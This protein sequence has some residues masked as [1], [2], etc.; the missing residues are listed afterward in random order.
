M[1]L[2]EALDAMA[3]RPALWIG[4]PP[5]S[6]KTTLARTWL[7]ARG[8]TYRWLQLDAAD[9]DP[10]TF[11]QL[12]DDA[13]A[14]SDPGLAGTVPPPAED[15]L[16]D[17][18]RLL[19]RGIRRL[20]AALPTPWVLVLD[21]VQKLG[22]ASRLLDAFPAALEVAGEHG[23]FVFIGRDPPPPS[24]SS[25]ITSQA[26]GLL[27][28]EALSF[29]LEETRAL[30][31]LHRPGRSA[32]D[33]HRVTEGWVA[34]MILMLAGG[35]REESRSPLDEG[36]TKRRLFAYFAEEIVERMPARDAETLGR[37]AFLPGTDA[38][39]AAT[40]GGDPDAGTLLADLAERGLFT[41]R[42]DASAQPVYSFHSLF[43]AFLRARL[44]ERL[45][46]HALL[47]VR[48]E[49][50]RLLLEQERIDAAITE[51]IELGAWPRLVGVLDGHAAGCVEQGRS[52]SLREWILALPPPH[53]ER[54]SMRY[55]LGICELSIDP[56]AALHELEA[57]Y[58]GYDAAGDAVGAFRAAAAAADAIVTLGESFASLLPWMETLETHVQGWLAR[59]DA[60]SDPLVLPGLLAA[61]VHL[62][63]GHPATLRLVRLAE[64]LLDEPRAAGQRILLGTTALYLLWNG[65]LS[66]LDR[67]MSRIDRLCE[68]PDTSPITLLR[69]YG[70][71]ILVRALLGRI[72]DARRDARSALALAERHPAALARAHLMAALAAVASR[73]ARGAR[74]HLERAATTVGPRGAIDRTTLDFHWALVRLLEGDPVAAS[75][76]MR[77]SITAGRASGWPLREHIALLGHAMAATEGGELDTAAGVLADALAHPFHGVCPWHRWL[78]AMVEANLADRR[79][80]LPGTLAALRRAFALHRTHGFDS[81]PLLHGTGD[82]MP[83]L[84]AVALAHGVGVACVP[85]IIR[86]YALPAPVTA[87]ERWPWPVRIR[88]LGGFTIERDDGALPASRKQSRMALDLLKLIVALG[89]TGVPIERVRA[90]LWPDADDASVRGS[91]DNTLHRLRKLLG[92]GHVTVVSGALS[93]NA[94][95]C[96]SDAGALE[97]CLRNAVL[98]DA[99]SA[100]A[101]VERALA[102]YRGP[103]LDG[104]DGYPQTALTR[105][106]LR[107]LFVRR[108]ESAGALLDAAGRLDESVTLYRRVLEQEPLAEG[109]Y[110]RLILCLLQ[111]GR[112]AEAFDAY[113]R[114]RQQ[115]SLVLGIRPSAATETLVA[116]LREP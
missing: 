98:A 17:L 9:D 53:R 26:L 45:S 113:R 44:E 115:L 76:L 36:L 106:R 8:E 96:W 116:A 58:H 3:A 81:G 77:E 51:L 30:I 46:P 93:L 114:C 66:R 108:M 24:F 95:T 49:A 12:L 89:G 18:P 85:G 110:R 20:D 80:D 54:A 97:A 31:A 111:L 2:F 7:D 4:G 52:R 62:R 41:Y 87:D 104:E 32:S 90:M 105:E 61:F 82:V 42:R 55:W 70:T 59:R 112:R 13:L 100:A 47:A 29:D 23:R 1:R 83:R 74:E 48:L 65:R 109:V 102:L 5:G 71:A 19:R 25:A 11:L 6:G 103:F 34:A 43:G 78:G 101:L 72:D 94:A 27:D 39:T 60:A 67:L 92:E 38:A 56:A 16:R 40:I 99:D 33:L 64:A 68:D 73:D 28:A 22:A 15:D 69:W 57:A 79:R 50:V 37:V 35:G 107:S 21:N 86:R 84:C 88:T 91:F 75:R 10:A 14:D 63:T